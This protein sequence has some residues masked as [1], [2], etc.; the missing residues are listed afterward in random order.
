MADHNF[1]KAALALLLCAPSN[2]H[3]TWRDS[4]DADVWRTA[5]DGLG[6]SDGARDDALVTM[7]NLKRGIGDFTSMANTLKNDP[8]AGGE[9]HPDPP[10]AQRIVAEMRAADGE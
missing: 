8:W 4:D 1:Q 6:F 2:L 9:P 7:R 10:G 5:L 3:D